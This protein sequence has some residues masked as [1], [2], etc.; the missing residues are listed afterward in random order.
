MKLKAE[1][2]DVISWGMREGYSEAEIY[3][4][5][6]DRIDAGYSV[7]SVQLRFIAKAFSYEMALLWNGM[8]K[9]AKRILNAPYLVPPSLLAAPVAYKVRC[10]LLY[11]ADA[12]E[13]DK[14][15]LF[16]ADNGMSFT[17]ADMQSREE[18]EV[19]L[20]NVEYR[21]VTNHV[22]RQCPVFSIDIPANK[23]LLWIKVSGA[24]VKRIFGGDRVLEAEWI[25]SELISRLSLLPVIREGFDS[26]LLS[27]HCRRI[28]DELAFVCRMMER[29][30]IEKMQM[31]KE[32]VG[33]EP[34][35]HKGEAVEEPLSGNRVFFTVYNNC[36]SVENGDCDNFTGLETDDEMMTVVADYA[37]CST[38]RLEKGAILKCSK[39]CFARSVAVEVADSVCCRYDEADFGAAFRHAASW[40]RI[41]SLGDIRDSSLS[42]FP[43][44][45]KDV[46]AVKGSFVKRGTGAVSGIIVRL[47]MKESIGSHERDFWRAKVEEYLK[48]NSPSTYNYMV[49]VN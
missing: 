19:I 28:V 21:R 14:D 9:M 30:R 29:M 44:V 15:D 18:G 38:G 40:K 45:L 4:R 31:E 6:L 20:E 13:L 37:L 10:R 49:L 47:C 2:E 23:R 5:L 22:S 39:G 36:L 17:V 26:D 1:R 24:K 3:R 33:T 32:G 27:P 12:S 34:V 11:G 8:D 43:H 41:W 42:L 7:D 48:S 46:S 25:M 16:V 35:R